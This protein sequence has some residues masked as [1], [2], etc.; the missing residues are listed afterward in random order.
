MNRLRELHREFREALLDAS[1][2]L[3]HSRLVGDQGLIDTRLAIYRNNVFT[4]LREA[5]R[6]FYPVVNRCLLYTSPSPRD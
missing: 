6:T 5:L 4:N 1:A 3:R 2:T